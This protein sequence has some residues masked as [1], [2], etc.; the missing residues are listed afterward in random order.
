MRPDAT[1]E[2][3]MRRFARTALLLATVTA[4]AGCASDVRSDSLT[5]TL[6]Q[7]A[8]AIRWG[9]YA[10]AQGLVDKDYAAEHPMSSLEQARL[11]QLRVTG[12]DEGA[13]PRPDGEDEVVQT[14]QISVVN[15]NTQ[16]ERSFI[17][18]QR[19]H[20]DKD[21]SRWTLMTGLPDFS[22]H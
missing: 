8:S 12:Y 13:G 6:N 18:H 5:R 3:A 15:V 1:L 11:G 17:D 21:K 4:L 2:P 14:V 7:Y 22:P 16:A 10:A 20:Y 19:W 9:D